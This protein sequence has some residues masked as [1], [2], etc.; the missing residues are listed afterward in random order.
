VKRILSSEQ[1]PKKSGRKKKQV[2]GPVEPPSD[3]TGTITWACGQVMVPC[4]IDQR[5]FPYLDIPWRNTSFGY[6][7]DS[8]EDSANPQLQEFLKPRAEYSQASSIHF[9]AVDVP[10]SIPKVNGSNWYVEVGRGFA[11]FQERLP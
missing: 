7:G 10:Y 4:L 6:P 5:W 9:D 8:R 2:E 1:A 3:A 11:R